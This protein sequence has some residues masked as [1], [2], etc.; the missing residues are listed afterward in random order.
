M[1][2]RGVGVTSGAEEAVREDPKYLG[3]FA[4]RRNAYVNGAVLAC[5]VSPVTLNWLKWAELI[6]GF[7]DGPNKVAL[8]LGQC[9]DL[10]LLIICIRRFWTESVLTFLVMSTV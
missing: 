4:E 9:F 1:G 6:E 8:C 5:V 10:T 3:G 2:Q 7:H